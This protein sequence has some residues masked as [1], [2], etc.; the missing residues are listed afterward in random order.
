M[1]VLCSSGDKAGPDGKNSLTGEAV[2]SPPS[3]IFICEDG[4][5]MESG[6]KTR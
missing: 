6:G 5:G 1:E 2:S 3:A 4:C